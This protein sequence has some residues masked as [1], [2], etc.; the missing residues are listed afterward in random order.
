MG[1]CVSDT[2][3][4]KVIYVTFNELTLGGQQQQANFKS[5]LENGDYYA[6]LRKIE[7]SDN[8]IGKGRFPQRLSTKCL[9]THIP[10]YIEWAITNIYEK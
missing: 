9:K 6:C 8:G 2:K 4:Q 5:E 7:N 1:K 3:A 10:R